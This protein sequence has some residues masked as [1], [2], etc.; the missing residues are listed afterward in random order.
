MRT[1]AFRLANWGAV[2]GLFAGLAEITVGA[3]IRPWI[4]NKENPFVLGLVTLLL[5]GIAR[6]TA[7]LAQKHAPQSADSKLAT[8]LGVLL[9]A[10]ICFTTVGV[11]WYLPGILLLVSAALLIADFWR[12]RSRSA[13]Q[14]W[15]WVSGIGALIGLASF[16]AALRRDTFGLFSG[17]LPVQADRLL[18][19]ILPMDVVRRT[20]YVFGAARTETFES[21]TVMVVYLLMVLGAS[22]SLLAGLAASPLFA[23]VGAVMNL[24]GI[25][26]FLWQLPAILNR[27]NYQSA[28]PVWASLGAGWYLSVLSMVLT[29]L[30]AFWSGSRRKSLF[31]MQSIPGGQS[32]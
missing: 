2:L 21:S 14:S 32:L 20:V 26:L 24:A 1:L 11:L 25:L 22:V 5:S 6:V 12:N 27:A 23:K 17:M 18:V 9:P 3:S 15:R 4:G 28:V 7:H 10:G 8:L 16:S 19:Q 29:L 30:G 31:K 13:I